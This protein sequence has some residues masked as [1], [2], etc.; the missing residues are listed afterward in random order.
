MGSSE[1][2][3]YFSFMERTQDC[4]WKD[5]FSSPAPPL[6]PMQLFLWHFSWNYF[7]QSIVLWIH[8]LQ[9]PWPGFCH[10]CFPSTSSVNSAARAS[11][12]PFPCEN[13]NEFWPCFPFLS[14]SSYSICVGIASQIHKFDWCLR[15]LFFYSRPISSGQMK[16]PGDKHSGIRSTFFCICV[17]LCFAWVLSPCIISNI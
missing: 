3:K 5:T 17:W 13:D 12:I 1:R 8:L 4:R 6:P 11:T 10:V 14:H 15:N 16:I 7:Q 2:K 9:W